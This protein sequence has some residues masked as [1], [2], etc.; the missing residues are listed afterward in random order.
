[1]YTLIKYT[2]EYRLRWNTFVKANH[3]SVFHLIEWKEV[4]ELAF[5]YKGMYLLAIENDGEIA[6]VVPLIAGRD[7]LM[8]KVGVSL[9]FVNYMD[10]CCKDESVF[11]FIV[12]E[13]YKV[14]DNCALKHIEMRFKTQ[15]LKEPKVLLNDTNFTLAIPLDGDEE[16]VLSY[17]NGNNRNHVRKVYKNQ[18]FS[19]SFD[20]ANLKKFYEIYCKTMKRLGS[21]VPDYRFFELILKKLPADTRLLTVIDN[22][23][24]EV[25]GGMFLFT[26][27]DNVYYQWGGSLTEYNKKYVNNFMYWE[28][29]KFGLRSGYKQ[30]DLGRSPY[31]S[32]TYKFKQQWGAVPHQ[33]KYYK[34]GNNLSGTEINR[35][36]MSLAVSMWRILPNFLTNAMG[37]ILIK[38]VM[39]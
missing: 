36:N 21:P 31:E 12:N 28:A 1:M 19:V 6:G 22:E 34:F 38:Y 35:E 25:I 39:P 2:D 33:L 17:S 15:E 37:K 30:L 5:G 27:E 7:L 8:R 23:N 9:P 3:G 13:L 20:N 10:L 26:D 14:A 16:Q 11:H 29:V 4:L 24:G 32:G 18:Y